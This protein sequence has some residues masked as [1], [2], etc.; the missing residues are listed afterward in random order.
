[1]ALHQKEYR[2]FEAAQNLK[3]DLSSLLDC[4]SDGWVPPEN[5][6]AAKTGNKAMFEGMWQAVLANKHPD[7]DEPIRDERDLRDIWPFDL[8]E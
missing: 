4:A 7:E 8:P 2:S 6:A 1:M 3:R 5:W